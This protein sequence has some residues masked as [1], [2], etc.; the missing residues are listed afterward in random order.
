M[1]ETSSGSGQRRVLHV[2]KIRVP[3]YEVDLGGGVYHGNYFHL[4][5][6]AR[7]DFMRDLG[8]PYSRFMKQQLHLA[9]AEISC[10]YQRPL[11]YDDMIEIHTEVPERRIRSLSFLHTIYRD[12][13]D[14]GPAVCTQ[15]RMNMVCIRF[16]GLSSVIPSEFV[17]LLDER[18]QRCGA[19]KSGRD[20]L[21]Q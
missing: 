21:L 11:F 9:V 4:F 20:E 13:G 1:A 17:S 12:D 2:T 5:E 19:G 3:L 8:Y 10:I 14:R 7:E 18:I 6:I 16:T 15:T